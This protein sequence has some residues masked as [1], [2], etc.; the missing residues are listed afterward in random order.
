[1]KAF[2]VIGALVL[3]VIA[4]LAIVSYVFLRNLDGIVKDMIEDVGT[5]VTGTPVSLNSVKIDLKTGKGKLSG[6]T[7]ANPKGYKSNYALKLDTIAV[8]IS[9]KSLTEP[10][11]VITQV[12]IDGA[13]LIA[14][15]RGQKTNLSD[16]LENM[17]KSGNKGSAKP[18][19]KSSEPSADEVHLMIEK[20]AFINTQATVI[21]EYT[22]QKSI[23][24][25]DIRRKNIGD[26]KTGLT[27]EQLTQNLLSSIMKQ[28]Q[29]AVAQYLGK[30]AVD[31]AEEKLTEKLS[32]E[33]S[34]DDMSKVEGLKSFFKKDSE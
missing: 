34:P 32:E 4:I 2:K 3:G 31:A 1:M 24:I 18:E 26:K 8:G 19:P 23:K 6:L 21:S 15:Q 7:I 14:E 13:K 5:Q 10:V 12:K 20:F 27:P 11:I 28:V 17:E 22:E 9:P 33:L 29:N 30:V 25:P 16:L